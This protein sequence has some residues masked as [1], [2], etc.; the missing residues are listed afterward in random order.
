M[1]NCK[2]RGFINKVASSKANYL[3]VTIL[4]SVAVV[5]LG[6]L[7]LARMIDLLIGLGV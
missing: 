4:V 7:I 3:L 6:S 5:G 2:T 1:L